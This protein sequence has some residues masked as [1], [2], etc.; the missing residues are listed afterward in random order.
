MINIQHK[1]EP[2][3]VPVKVEVGVYREA[4]DSNRPVVGPGEFDAWFLDEAGEPK[5]RGIMLRGTEPPP[6]VLFPRKLS[7]YLRVFERYELDTVRRA[8]LTYKFAGLE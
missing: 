5:R 8:P 1:D 3:K 2:R 6:T 4:G 7:A